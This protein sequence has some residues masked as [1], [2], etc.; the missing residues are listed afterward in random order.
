[1]PNYRL[2]WN[3]YLGSVVTFGG[4]PTIDCTCNHTMTATGQI[5]TCS[6]PLSHMGRSSNQLPVLDTMPKVLCNAR[7]PP[8]CTSFSFSSI[9]LDPDVRIK[10]RWLGSHELS[11]LVIESTDLTAG[12]RPFAIMN[13]TPPSSPSGALHR[14]PTLSDMHSDVTA[15]NVPQVSKDSPFLPIKTPVVPRGKCADDQPLCMALDLKSILC[16]GNL[17]SAMQ[18]EMLP[19]VL[20]SCIMDTLDMPSVDISCRA[21]TCLRVTQYDAVME[22]LSEYDGDIYDVE[23]RPSTRPRLLRFHYP[24]IFLHPFEKMELLSVVANRLNMTT[25]FGIG[26]WHSHLHSLA[27]PEDPVP[28]TCFD[29]V[30]VAA[31]SLIV[32]KHSLEEDEYTVVN[33]GFPTDHLMSTHFPEYIHADASHA[34]DI[35]ES[36]NLRVHNEE[37]SS[38]AGETTRDPDDLGRRNCIKVLLDDGAFAECDCSDSDRED[39]STQVDEF[40][41]SMIDQPT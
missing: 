9:H 32:C 38:Q 33:L 12:F 15:Y 4:T 11:S 13:N 40:F 20:N 34:K 24:Y 31:L 39:Y 1:M 10:S 18:L 17:I 19:N 8:K 14:P 27:G 41:D 7:P 26:N 30:N 2:P 25:V 6:W 36:L 37:L 28:L 22:A 35:V 29:W 23:G 5:S 21:L 3:C 16:C